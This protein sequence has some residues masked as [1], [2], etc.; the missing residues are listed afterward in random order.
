VVQVLERGI[1]PKEASND[2]LQQTD[3]LLL[4]ELIDHVAKNCADSIKALV[5]LTDVRQANIIKQD[6]LHDKNCNGLAEFGAGLHDTKTERDDFGRQEEV[7]D[8]GRVVL[9]KRADDTK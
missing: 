4:D 3:S 6:L 5:G 9:D 7:D 1:L 2:V 8:L